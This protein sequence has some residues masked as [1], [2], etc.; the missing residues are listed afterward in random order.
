MLLVSSCAQDAETLPQEFS[1]LGIQAEKW[2]YHLY[3]S[4]EESRV[5][6][7]YKASQSFHSDDACVTSAHV[8]LANAHHVTRFNISGMG[9]AVR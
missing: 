8:P 1:C 5:V 6:E 4:G 2:M 9:C 7:T 3:G